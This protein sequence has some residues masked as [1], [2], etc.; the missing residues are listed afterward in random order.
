MKLTQDTGQEK[1]PNQLVDRYQRRI[2]Y[3]RFSVT[4]RCDF[5]CTY[6]MSEKMKFLPRQ[7]I[8][9]LEEL[10]FLATAFV[11]LGVS[12][13]RITGGEP[14]VR[15]NV[16]SLFDNLGKI[17][18]LDQFVMTTNGSQ[19]EKFA[20]PLKDAGVKRINISL[21]SLRKD[22]FKAITRTGDLEEVLKG[23]KKAR[24]VGFEKLKINSVIMRGENDD[25][26]FDLIHFARDNDLDITFIEEMPLGNISDHHRKNT[27]VSSDWLR[28]KITG[29]FPLQAP[30]AESTFLEKASNGPSKYFTM[31][32]SNS[33]VGFI[34]PHSHNFCDTCNRVRVTAEGRLLL[35]LGNEHSIDLRAVLRQHPGNMA[36]LKSTIVAAMD[37]KPKSHEFNLD[38]EPRILRFM[39][40]T[41]G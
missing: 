25:E 32:D 20:Q 10:Y 37:I 24:E 19:L 28:E 40:Q 11:E 39:N 30:D 35:C 3:V 7:K 21:D 4:D 41:G 27:Y 29:V 5:R 38:D 8:L 1:K 26:I 23:I 18:G 2:N 22:R 6:C 31:T 12:K 16:I 15:S 36:I 13:I 14:M 33:R 17:K 9:T 34:S